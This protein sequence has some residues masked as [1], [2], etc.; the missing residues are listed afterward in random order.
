[1]TRI[2]SFLN[3]NEVSSSSGPLPLLSLSALTAALSLRLSCPRYFRNTTWASA[4]IYFCREPSSSCYRLQHREN[5]C[6]RGGCPLLFGCR[7]Q[8]DIYR[9]HHA[10]VRDVGAEAIPGDGRGLRQTPAMLLG[11]TAIFAISATLIPTTRTL[12]PGM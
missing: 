2:V 3:R 5:P 1:M 7:G 6:R 4:T 10:A 12:P 8:G 9:E 11:S